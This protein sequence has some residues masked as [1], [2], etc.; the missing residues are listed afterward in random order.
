MFN[1]RRSGAG[2]HE[3][4]ARLVRPIKWPQSFVRSVPGYTA[5]VAKQITREQAAR[6]KAQAAGFMNRIG[7][8][9]RAQESTT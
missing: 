3:N 7:Q 1:R 2:P 8:P 6:K 5:V 9:D 4:P